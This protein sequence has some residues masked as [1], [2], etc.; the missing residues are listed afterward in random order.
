MYWLYNCLYVGL[1]CLVMGDI[2]W[3]VVYLRDEYKVDMYNG[4]IF[5]YCYV[6][7]NL[8]EVE[9]VMWML[10]VSFEFWGWLSGWGSYGGWGFW[11]CFE[12]GGCQL[13]LWLK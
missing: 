8:Q 10:M 3:L 11:G 12:L 6:K 5:N 2:V 7:L 13:F 1:E 4:F 9:N